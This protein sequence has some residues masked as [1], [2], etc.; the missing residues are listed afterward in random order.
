V[1]DLTKATTRARLEIRRE[2][3]WQK[4]GKGR[5]LGFRRMSSNS[6]G[7]WIARFYDSGQAK[8]HFHPLGD[9]GAIT[10]S[11]RYG[12]ALKS[13]MK[14]FSHLDRGGSAS[15]LTMQDIA[16]R[17]VDHVRRTR[18]ETA[19]QDVRRRLGTYVLTYTPFEALDVTKLTATHLDR[20]RRWMVDRPSKSGPN[21][22]G[23][24][25]DATQNRDI[26]ALRSALNLALADGLLTTDAPW[27]KRLAPI[28]GADRRRRVFLT[29]SDL[30]RLIDATSPDFRDFFTMLRL[31][32]IRPGA[33]AAL[34]VRDLNPQLQSI[35]IGKDKANGDRWIS[36]P[37]ETYE[38]IASFARGKLPGAP[39]VGSPTGKHWTR[40]HWKVSFSR[41]AEIA[42]L[43]EDA[44]TY[45]IRH[46]GISSLLHEGVDPLTV[47]YLAG[48]SL[49]VIATFYAHAA[50]DRVRTALEHL[51]K[52]KTSKAN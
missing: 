9:F 27:K 31:I 4:I 14:W 2:P 22:G 10:E 17:Y 33:A 40:H 20:W 18:G 5:Y 25:T 23:Q 39:L 11:E 34:K 49:R 35:R 32:P 42:G 36:L 3:H 30:D 47:S 46:S 21:R 19:A 45:T 8:Q 16:D 13:A 6:R 24:R 12:E 7:Q 44:V 1:T 50:D 48:T 38:A 41:A 52:V 29:P 28:K 15:S 51:A 43:P 26:T 37:R